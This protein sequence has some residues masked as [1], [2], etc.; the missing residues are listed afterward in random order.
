VTKLKKKEGT[1]AQRHKVK[2]KENPGVLWIGSEN[3]LSARS[4]SLSLLIKESATK[5]QFGDRINFPFHT[6]SFILFI[7]SDS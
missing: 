1:K 7:Y 2:E 3:K 6:S 4:A 5:L